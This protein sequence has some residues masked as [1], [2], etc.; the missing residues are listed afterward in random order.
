METSGE[1]TH[2]SFVDQL[3]SSPTTD[4]QKAWHISSMLLSFRRPARPVELAFRCT[5]FRAT[6]E[7]IEYLCCIPN[8]PI[9]LTPSYYVTLSSF[10]YLAIAEFF[11]NSSVDLDFL[12]RLKFDLEFMTYFRK[13]KRTTMKEVFL[14]E[15]KKRAKGDNQEVI[16]YYYAEACVQD[17]ESSKGFTTRFL[18][19]SVES[20]IKDTN[21]E[22]CSSATGYQDFPPHHLQNF[23]P[24]MLEHQKVKAYPFQEVDSHST[25]QLPVFATEAP[26]SEGTWAKGTSFPASSSL[27]LESQNAHPAKQVETA[28]HPSETMVE[29][30]KDIESTQAVA[31]RESFVNLLIGMTRKGQLVMHKLL[32][33]VAEE[34]KRIPS[35]DME[36]GLELLKSQNATELP[37]EYPNDQDGTEIPEELLNN[38]DATEMGKGPLNN[39]EL[40]ISNSLASVQNPLARTSAN[41]K[42]DVKEHS[43]NGHFTTSKVR[44]AACSFTTQGQTKR[45]NKSTP[46]KLHLKCND[47]RK[48]DVKEKHKTADK[49]GNSSLMSSQDQ[50]EH[51]VLPNFESFVVEEEEGS[52]GYG[53]VYRAKRKT[54]GVT[55]AIKSPHVNANRNHVHNEVKMLERFGGKNFVIRYEGSIKRGNVDCLVL[56]HV[57]HDRPEALKKEIDIC[58]LQW[59]GYCMFRALAALHKQGI[60]HRD[61]KPGN[62]LFNRK[63]CKGYLIDFNLAMDLNHK[64]FNPGKSKED[65]DMNRKHVPTSHAKPLPPMKSKRILTPENTREANHGHGKVSKLAFGKDTKKRFENYNRNAEVSTR[66]I[67]KS[68]GAEGSGITSAKDAT[69]TKTPST[70]K[71]REPL[72][73]QGRKELINLVQEALQGANREG[74][75]VTVSR[76]KRVAAPPGKGDH[77]FVYLTPMPLQSA[78]GVVGGAGLLKSKGD[79]KVKREG[80]CVGT[81]G[82][83]APEVLF[84]SLHQGPK[85][86]MWSAG[87]TLLYLMLGRAPFVGDPD[88]NAKEIAKLRGSEDLWEVAK[89]HNCES[90]FPMELFDIKFLP[91]MKLQ[92]WCKL[93]TRRPDFLK[94]IPS[95][96]F[97]LVDKC[98]TV[99]PRQRISAEEALRHEFFNPCHEALRKHR[100]LRQGVNLD[101]PRSSS[102]QVL[103]HSQTCKEVS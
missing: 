14:Q 59:Y 61:V 15:S 20:N 89:L 71:F 47:K 43:Q 4:T 48:T 32:E 52:G 51:R 49:I 70:E 46:S 74:G 86:D 85:I 56:E 58:E 91:S 83:R 78:G 79:G 101:D 53:T 17:N 16:P 60:V 30:V 81:K 13:R 28:V 96:L 72:P 9:L 54:D 36:I 23:F 50:L 45:D 63:A 1:L 95:S 35:A 102:N 22:R 88:Q 40:L 11:S 69:S 41:L 65:H 55:F 62:F 93:N 77:K 18:A 29:A 26:F 64:Y 19:N 5:L 68:Q 24:A 38:Q 92:D 33:N 66:S 80:P 84:R 8:S 73:C 67:I 27:K 31:N 44:D 99:N 25:L 39:Q 3:T 94:V 75:N 57:E 90:S 34:Y 10:G 6:P 87:V 7:L 98:L 2:A 76:R 100:L 103:G 82:F 42:F 21:E 37:K 97:D 12:P